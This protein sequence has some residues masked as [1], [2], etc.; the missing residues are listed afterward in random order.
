M[1]GYNQE[2]NANERD[3]YII[4]YMKSMKMSTALGIDA[5]EKNRQIKATMNEDRKYGEE[6]RLARQT[7]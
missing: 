7:R 4:G 5:S 3:E 6:N 2:A 1:S